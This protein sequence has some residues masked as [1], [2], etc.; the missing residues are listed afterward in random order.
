[1]TPWLCIMA[2][3][4]ALR[5]G[6]RLIDVA[7]VVWKERVRSRSRCAEMHAAAATRVIMYEH[8]EDNAVLLVTPYNSLGQYEGSS[9]DVAKADPPETPIL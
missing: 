5:V 1:M 6:I 4:A 8:R 7:G 9:S 3:P 2:L